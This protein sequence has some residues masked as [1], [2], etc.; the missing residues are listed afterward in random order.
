MFILIPLLSIIVITLIAK[1][2]I[3]FIPTNLE[4][5]RCPVCVGVAGTW[6]WMLVAHGFGLQIPE[7]IIALFVGG[8]VVGIA[9]TIEKSLP[10]QSAS[11]KHRF[12]WGSILFWKTWFLTLGFGAAFALVTFQFAVFIPLILILI[13]FTAASTRA[14]RAVEKTGE[15]KAVTEIEKKLE[16]CC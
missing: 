12:R 10:V 2:S 3:R 15:S 9:F 8:S 5:I 16:N 13:V 14:I 7:T 11:L 1:K 4:S 6:L